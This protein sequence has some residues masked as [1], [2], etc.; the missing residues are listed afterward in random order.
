MRP[1][2][3]TSCVLCAQNCGLLGACPRIDIS[4]STLTCLK[5]RHFETKD[6]PSIFC[7]SPD[8]DGAKGYGLYKK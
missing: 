8:Q 3:P 1:W 2:L 7:L 6:A 5:S 4:E